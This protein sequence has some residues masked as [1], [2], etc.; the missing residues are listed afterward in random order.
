MRSKVK[1]PSEA[2]KFKIIRKI[3]NYSNAEFKTDVE[4]YIQKPLKPVEILPL[5]EVRSSIS[6]LFQREFPY[7]HRVIPVLLVLLLLLTSTPYKDSFNRVVYRN[8]QVELNI[9]YIRL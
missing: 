9:L 2:K 3:G 8:L 6:S 4:G 7:R 1:S 5:A